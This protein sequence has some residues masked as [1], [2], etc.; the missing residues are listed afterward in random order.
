M[1]AT[2]ISLTMFGC[3]GVVLGGL[4]ANEPQKSGSPT[5]CVINALADAA[6]APDSLKRRFRDF[7]NIGRFQGKVRLTPQQH[8]MLAEDLD[9]NGVVIE[10]T[11]S[12]KQ[13][14]QESS[15][16]LIPGISK[17]FGVTHR[18]FWCV[19]DSAPNA[20]ATRHVYPIPDAINQ[21]SA[22]GLDGTI[23]IGRTLAVR[24][25]KT[26]IDPQT[27]LS[28]PYSF[29]AVLAHEC[30]HIRQ[31]KSN[32]MFSRIKYRELHADYLAGWL[33]NH[34]VAEK[35]LGDS[36]VGDFDEASAMAAVYRLGDSDFNNPEHHGT[37]GERLRA[38]LAGFDGHWPAIDAAYAKGLQYVKSIENKDNNA[39]GA[40]SK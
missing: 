2:S 15:M 27:D 28:Q 5:G 9:E 29:V 6:L 12:A 19:D 10:A 17:L 14:G 13:K 38:F 7:Q 11:T 25:L 26:D 16:R 24:L 18:T 40:V 4:F 20:Y 35:K 34:V 30:A 33:V 22:E 32:T 23:I 1:R 31:F 39:V 21:P 37:K 8:I 3:V 36:N